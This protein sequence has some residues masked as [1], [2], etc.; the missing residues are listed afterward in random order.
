MC[1]GRSH[2]SPITIGMTIGICSS[3]RSIRPSC[4]VGAPV[5]VC[6]AGGKLLHLLGSQRGCSRVFPVSLLSLCLPSCL[7]F[8]LHPGLLLPCHRAGNSCTPP[9]FCL[10]LCGFSPAPSA[11]AAGRPPP[12]SLFPAAL[13]VTATPHRGATGDPQHR[14][15]QETGSVSS[16]TRLGCNH[17]HRGS[18]AG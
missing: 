5:S 1:H 3:S 4:S 17:L 6:P 15:H 13:D 16:L 12:S 8:L 14:A 11:A 9:R 7:L 18:V 10:Q 2:Q